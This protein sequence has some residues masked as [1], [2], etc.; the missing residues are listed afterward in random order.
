MRELQRDDVSSTGGALSRRPGRGRSS[1]RTAELDVFDAAALGASTSCASCSTPSPGSSRRSRTTASPRS[2][3]RASRAPRP[4][5]CSSSAVRRSNGSRSSNRPGSAARDGGVR[6]RSRPPESCSRRAPTRTV[7]TPASS[8]A[9]DRRGERARGA[10]PAAPR[11]RGYAARVN[12]EL[13]ADT[14]AGAANPPIAPARCGSGAR[15]ASGYEEMTN[16]SRGLRDELAAAV[17]FSTLTVEDEG[18]GGR[19]HRRR[20]SFAPPTGIRS[21]R[22]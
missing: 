7:S 14:L 18:A 13:L 1:G 11:A 20:R 16:L 3:S 6:A 15:G 10:R 2:I 5:G 21:K 19:R 9:A 4:F 12:L 17:P 8:V 22:C